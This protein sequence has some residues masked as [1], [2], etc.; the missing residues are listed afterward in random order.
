MTDRSTA[1]R[2]LRRWLQSAETTAAE[3]VADPSLPQIMHIQTDPAWK[4]FFGD[5]IDPTRHKHNFT[6]V[7]TFLRIAESGG[8]GADEA[9]VSASDILRQFDNIQKYCGEAAARWTAKKL[10]LSNRQRREAGRTPKRRQWADTLAERIDHWDAI[11]ESPDY[12]EIEGTDHDVQCYRDG[13]KVCCVDAS[14]S[15]EIGHLARSTFE[16]RYLKKTAGQK[17]R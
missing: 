10:A 2:D 17:R 14:T 6:N 7:R 4:T 13:E 8:P 1:I 9:L 15:N 5:A 3:M 12:L 11:P 16:K